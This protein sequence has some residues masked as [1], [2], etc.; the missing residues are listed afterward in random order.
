MA[1]GKQ[2][3]LVARAPI[4]AWPYRMDHIA[5][6][7]GISTCG[8]SVADSATAK[9]TTFLKQFTTGCTMDRPVD[10]ASALQFGIGGVDDRF[11]ILVGDVADDDVK[12]QVRGRRFQN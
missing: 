12:P 11:T 3:R 9:S 5:R 1:S 4:P 8:F 7:Q 10:A 2:G 6:C